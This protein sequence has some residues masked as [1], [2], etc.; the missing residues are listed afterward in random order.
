M[1]SRVGLRS[2]MAAALAG[3]M[4]VSGAAMGRQKAE[5]AKIAAQAGSAKNTTRPAAL[6]SVAGLKID[7]RQNL[8]LESKPGEFL[9]GMKNANLPASTPNHKSFGDLPVSGLAANRAY[10]P[11]AF[12]SS[13]LT[14]VVSS[15]AAARNLNANRAVRPQKP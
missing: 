5:M 1:V 15:S 8:V 9:A 14:K 13:P 11:A 6:R 12:S 4:L 10:R 2:W 7:R 3:T